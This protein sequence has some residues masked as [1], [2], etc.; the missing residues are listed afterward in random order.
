MKLPYLLKIDGLIVITVS[1]VILYYSQV[2]FNFHKLFRDKY[3][4]AE[5]F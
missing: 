3:V 1:A 2:S 5:I 4:V